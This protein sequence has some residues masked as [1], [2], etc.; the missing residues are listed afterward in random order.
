M[1]NKIHLLNLDHPSC[2]VAGCPVP[3][4]QPICWI[5]RANH[6]KEVT[7]FPS[8]TPPSS[9]RSIAANLSRII[10]RMNSQEESIPFRKQSYSDM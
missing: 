8:T 10:F 3:H 1:E 2:L 9:Q 6:W 7:L 4:S 5:A